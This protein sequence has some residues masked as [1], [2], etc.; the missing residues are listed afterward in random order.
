MK[1]YMTTGLWMMI[2][3]LLAS[4]PV[5]AVTEDSPDILNHFAWFI[6]SPLGSGLLIAIGLSCIVIEVMTSGFG[7]FG[8]IG[9]VSFFLYFAGH[10]MFDQFSWIALILFA[11]GMLL[12]MLE[13]FV[14]TG[15][16]V[17][18]LAGI[19]AIFAGVFLLS[20]SVFNG[21]LT[22]LITVVLM[23]LILVVSFRFMK[24]KKIIHRFVLKDRTD[25]ESGYTSPNMDNEKYLG[26]EGMTISPLRPAGGMRINGDRVDVVS[27]GDFI[28]AGV[29]VR[30]IGIDGTRIL[31]R[32]VE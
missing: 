5:V 14:L 25:T 23:I 15:F 26:M 6:C 12:L 4:S 11:V 30:V 13:A 21:A 17:S 2:L 16:G 24:K 28:D 22:L 1:R 31:V 29:K 10:M 8:I 7:I 27:E 32:A 20:S 18:G 3:I 19:V 9:M